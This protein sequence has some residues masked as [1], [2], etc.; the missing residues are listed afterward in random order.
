MCTLCY[1]KAKAFSVEVDLVVALLKDLG[2]VPCI[3]K[4][5]QV[6]VAAALL[7]GI[8]DQLGRSCLTL[9]PHDRGLLLLPRL[10][11]NEG[12]ALGLLLRYLLGFDCGG[13]FGGEGEMLLGALEHA[14]RCDLVR[15]G[16]IPSEIRR[17]A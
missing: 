13:E 1:V 12:G 7:D 6:D 11:D 16:Y 3:L 14:Y 9:R 5:T 2:N 10:V 8:S 4:L 15:E 17:P